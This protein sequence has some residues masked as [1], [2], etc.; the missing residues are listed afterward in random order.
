L[1]RRLGDY[2]LHKAQRYSWESVAGE[3]I[4]VYQEAIKSCG[5]Q[6]AK[7]LEVASVHNAV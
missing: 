7:R 4:N 3:V 1:R 2:A 5:A 6:T